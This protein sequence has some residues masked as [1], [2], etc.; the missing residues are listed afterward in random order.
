MPRLSLGLDS[1]QIRRSAGWLLL[2]LLSIAAGVT[3]A[4]LLRPGAETNAP[5]SSAITSRRLSLAI[6]GLCEGQVSTAAGN[7]AATRASF[8]DKSHQ[9]LH[10]LAAAAA[11]RDRQASTN[12]L[13]AKYQVENLLALPTGQAGEVAATAP[14]EVDPG[15]LMNAISV[16]VTAVQSAAATLGF[17]ADGCSA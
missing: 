1:R 6:E 4:F 13:L 11:E 12:L 2:L 17:N 9:F 15:K 16:L 14:A 7:P 8:L 10:D 3:L 5:P